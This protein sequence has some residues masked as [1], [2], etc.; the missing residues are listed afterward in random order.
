MVSSPASVSIGEREGRGP[1][2]SLPLA[3]LAHCSA[4]NDTGVLG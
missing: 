4:G 1:M 2:G 3:M